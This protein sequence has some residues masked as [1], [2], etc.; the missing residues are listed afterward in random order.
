MKSVA[1]AALTA[2][3][4]LVGR[5]YDVFAGPAPS[6]ARG[7]SFRPQSEAS[8]KYHLDRAATKR[9]RKR[10]EN[11]DR[12]IR[13]EMQFSLAHIERTGMVILG[14]STVHFNGQEIGT[15]RNVFVTPSLMPDEPKLEDK[16]VT[17]L[18]DIGR[19]A[20]AKVTTKMT[21]AKLIEAI[22]AAL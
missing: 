21:K 2:I 7:Y 10:V 3:G 17:E 4:G 18:L 8:K 22:R 11:I 6:H 15:A 5:G 13:G 14:K 20:G 12:V 1:L 19:E 9:A 16:T